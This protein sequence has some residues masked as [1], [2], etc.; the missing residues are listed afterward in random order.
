[1]SRVIVVDLGAERIRDRL[2]AL[3]TMTI[4]IGHQGESGDAPHP[5]SPDVRVVDVA[6][7]ALYGT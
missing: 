6:A 3:E 7:F 5:S 1:M 4:T 2:A